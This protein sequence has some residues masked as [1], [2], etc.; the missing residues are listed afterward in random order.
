VGAAFVAANPGTMEVVSGPEC[1]LANPLEIVAG[2]INLT[3]TPIVL[4]A[5]GSI[6]LGGVATGLDTL[7]YS[8]ELSLITLSGSFEAGIT[9]EACGSG[10]SY[11]AT[12][13]I[14]ASPFS[15]AVVPSGPFSGKG[16][17][18][19]CIRAG[20]VKGEATIFVNII[21]NRVS[22]SRLVIS[23]ITFEHIEAELTGFTIAG[24]ETDW[25]AWNAGVKAAFEA[26]WPVVG[27]EFV[28]IAR[29]A[30]NE[31]FLWKYT[32]SE[33]LELIGGDGS[34][35]GTCAPEL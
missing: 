10:D 29:V 30:V 25:A 8:Y 27:T 15:E 2:N 18:H 21:T 6:Q 3:L 33:F 20:Y 19:G 12:G 26:E 14:D 11:E 4:I 1:T 34:T 22:L 35:K 9:G 31:N 13:T 17:Y 5:E 16:S 7:W 28:N 32:L 24:R 23:E